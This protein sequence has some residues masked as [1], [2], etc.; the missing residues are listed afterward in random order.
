MSSLLR[1]D[2]HKGSPGAAGSQGETGE[3]GAQGIQGV[4]GERGAQ[5]DSGPLGPR[6]P[7]GLWATKGLKVT[8]AHRVNVAHRLNPGHR[9]S[10]GVYMQIVLYL[11]HCPSS[12]LLKD[13]M[14]PIPS[15]C[16]MLARRHRSTQWNPVHGY[17][18]PRTCFKAAGVSVAHHRHGSPIRAAALS[19]VGGAE[20]KLPITS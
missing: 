19:H 2:G 12:L 11:S 13:L 17:C 14:P 15:R 10:L 16:K 1:Q 4:V 7:Q 20:N 3:Q 8:A 6:G 5:G 9:A 18:I